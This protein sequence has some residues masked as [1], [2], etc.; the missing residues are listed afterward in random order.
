MTTCHHD[1]I[2]KAD[3]AH[4]LI[5]KTSQPTHTKTMACITDFPAKD[6]TWSD[7]SDKGVF[8]LMQASHPKGYSALQ[9][10]PCDLGLRR[11]GLQESL[12]P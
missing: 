1:D 5:I 3:A 6:M 12:R 8:S 4:N 7:A 10:P 11:G 2:S 9:L